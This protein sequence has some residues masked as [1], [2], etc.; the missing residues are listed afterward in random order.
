MN[1]LATGRVYPD[2]FPD[3]RP[4]T[5][6]ERFAN[7]P[8]YPTEEIAPVRHFPRSGPWCYLLIAVSA[9]MLLTEV[10]APV[11]L[12]EHLILPVV[13]TVAAVAAVVGLIAGSL[14]A[15]YRAVERG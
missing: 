5:R 11:W 12:P 6:V 15:V 13:E 14:D 10:L 1:A 9:L 2:D 8:N 4:A 7:A 3:R